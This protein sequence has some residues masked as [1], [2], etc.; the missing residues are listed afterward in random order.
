[1]ETALLGFAQG[2]GVSGKEAALLK[3]NF[4]DMAKTAAVAAAGIAAVSGAVVG[5]AVGMFKL[6]SDAANAGSKIYDVTVK[7][8]LTAETVST[9]K[10]ASDRTGVSMESLGTVVGR[11]SKVVGE[12]AQGSES[13]RETLTRLGI[14]PQEAIKDLDG[15]LGK[16][17]KR[18]SDLPDPISKATLAQQ[19]F[20]KAGTEL[21]KVIDDFKGDLPGA[22]AEAKRLG[23]TMSGENVRAADDFADKMQLV[24]SQLEMAKVKI[25]QQ[26]MPVFLNMAEKMS[27]WLSSNQGE[28]IRWGQSFAAATAAAAKGV[29]NLYKSLE[30]FDFF[31]KNFFRSGTWQ[32]YQDKV[33]NFRM[34]QVADAANAGQGYNPATNTIT[35]GTPANVDGS[36]IVP[37]RA[38]N[39][40]TDFDAIKKQ[41][42]EAKQAAEKAQKEAE[43][44]RK[45]QLAGQLGQIKALHDAELHA[46]N[47]ITEANKAAF[48]ARTITAT[49]YLDQRMQDEEAFAKQAIADI[50]K[51]YEIKRQQ[52]NLS[53]EQLKAL[54]IEE[55]NELQKIVDNRFARE[56]EA[57]KEAAE[58]TKKIAEESVAIL[59]DGMDRRVALHEAM[60]DRIVAVEAANARATGKTADQIAKL[61]EAKEVRTLQFRLDQLKKYSESLEEGSKAHLDVQNQIKILEE[62]LEELRAKNA[63]NQQKRDEEQAA[64]D[65]DKAIKAQEEWEKEQLRRADLPQPRITSPTPELKPTDDDPFLLWRISWGEFFTQIAEQLG[66]VE[67]MGQT[68]GNTME[69]VGKMLQRSF[70]QV[71]QAVGSVIQQ[72]VLYGK[73]GPA[74]MRQILAAALASIAAEAAVRAIYATALG[75]FLLATQQYDKAAS[76]FISAAVWGSIAVGSALA[77]RKIAGN[78]FSRET[79]GAF[80]SSGQSSS[81]SAQSRNTSGQ[82]QQYSSHGDDVTI[83]ES[84]INQAAPAA[85]VTLDIRPTDAFIVEVVKENI[86]NHGSLRTAV[87]DA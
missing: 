70:T 61:I 13:A 15:A 49:Q 62:K 77:G 14:E 69:G 68:F 42:E 87:Q 44:L 12:A 38:S 9:L 51:E 23:L 86:N 8:G 36:P 29:S 26:L 78:S 11:F 46:L 20:G 32:E 54:K 79:Q 50:T 75:F 58:T 18:I 19:A 33:A 3:N 71:A 10:L 24:S 2:A 34:G 45:K 64:R 16:V 65:A 85:R 1:M 84:G 63:L 4:T 66:I 56:K 83:I 72:W 21:L 40:L 35:A 41:Q 28:V 55:D 80:G 6:A 59:K 57:Q 48:E 81:G 43:D 25:G 60:G 17:F 7:T 67:S 30:D 37:Q 82:G 74:V 53:S 47:R 22:I 52:A 73:T 5:A 39:A 76:A 27:A 31:L